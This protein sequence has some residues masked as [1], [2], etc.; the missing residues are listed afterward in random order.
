[1]EAL[2]PVASAG[3]LE[4]QS[5]I[6]FPTAQPG[7]KLHSAMPRRFLC[8]PL[9]RLLGAGVLFGLLSLPGDL[10][11]AAAE[12]SLRIDRLFGPEVPTGNYKHPAS[13][14]E[15]SDGSIYVVFFSGKGEYHDNAAAV[16]G[17]RIPKGGGR[18]S[19]PVAIANNPFHS[20]GNA[21]VWEAPDRTVWLFYV[22]RYGE[23]WADSRIT[24]KISRDGA[25]TWSEPF[26]V[27][28]EAGTM[29]RSRPV[30]LAD[31]S[32]ILPA[33]SETG[34]DPEVDDGTNTSLFLRFDPKKGVWTES[35]RVGSRLGNIQPAAAVV[36]GDHLVAFCRRGG[37]YNGRP[38]GWMVRTESRDGGRTWSPGRDS[39]F[40]NPNAAVDFLRL[41][42]GHHL[43]VYNHSFTNRTPLTVALSTD[44]ARTFPHARNL[45]DAPDGDYGYPTA[46]QTR[47]GRLH[48]LFT[49]DE[50]TVVR[51]A[52]F[53]EDWIR[54]GKGSVPAPAGKP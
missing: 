39:G 27:T 30:V 2:N 11:A 47:D 42:N 40:P 18:P 41:A 13:F 37:D 1:M 16:F 12:P 23:V 6:R 21:V 48:V 28:F 51:H 17:S 31:G 14:T 35:N 49:S 46:L 26:Q 22:T 34:R 52:V 9:F 24:A 4:G 54:T 29:V 45:L 53:P 10:P 36:D 43:L 33:Y 5:R 15:L 7:A 38:D 19:K 25:R 20:L 32:W 50:R 3:D 8:R 44:G